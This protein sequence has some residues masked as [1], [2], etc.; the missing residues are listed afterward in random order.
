[1]MHMMSVLGLNWDDMPDMIGAFVALVFVLAI[2]F[3]PSILASMSSDKKKQDENS[4][5]TEFLG[6]AERMM[7]P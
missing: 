2:T 6:T 4:D 5:K 3:G 7:K 1:M